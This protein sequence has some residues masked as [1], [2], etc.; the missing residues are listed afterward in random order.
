MHVHVFKMSNKRGKDDPKNE[1]NND[2]ASE[3]M[4]VEENENIA[5]SQNS[6]E[7]E[8]E[9]KPH[10][11]LLPATNKRKR[12][13]IYLSTIP[14]YMNVTKIREVFSNYGK[15]GRVYLQLADSGK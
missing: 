8:E 13:I 5:D 9:M 15:V 3:H 1:N 6:S 10:K 11:R 2:A 14:R 12:G 7:I 4:E